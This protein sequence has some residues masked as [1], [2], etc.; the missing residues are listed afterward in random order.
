MIRGRGEGSVRLRAD[1]RW[2]VRLSLPDGKRKSIFGKTRVEVLNK[3][4]AVQR[5]LEKGTLPTDGRVTTGQYLDQWLKDL[6][7]SLDFKSHRQY[8]YEIRLHLLPTIGK[9]PLTKLTASHLNR[10]Y[11]AMLD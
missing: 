2:E 4:R 1:G 7:P 3:S 5:D 9:V 8:E 11:A 10:I 6:R